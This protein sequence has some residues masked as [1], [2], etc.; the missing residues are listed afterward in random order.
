M[1]SQERD[2][3]RIVVGVDGSPSSIAALRWA[4]RQ[5]KLTGCAVEAVTAWEYP[6]AYGW[7]PIV[8]AEDFG[9]DAQ[10][11]LAEALDQVSGLEPDVI[12]RESTVMG[13]PG[14]VLVSAVR[15][16]ELLVVG[17]GRH[18]GLAGAPL[19]SV[20]Q[21]CAHHAPCPVLIMCGT[22]FG[23]TS[24]TAAPASSTARAR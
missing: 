12:I 18:S 16:A 11:I 7:A 1:S 14:Q 2:D 9:G 8:V 6:P 5:A 10:K 22:S 24:Q 13:H 19:G 17:S 20:G 23:A 15:G 21:Y 3:R 4:I